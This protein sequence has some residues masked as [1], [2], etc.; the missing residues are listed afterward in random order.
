MGIT[1]AVLVRLKS[2]LLLGLVTS[3]VAC[4][5]EN[6][7]VDD[8]G[9]TDA[10]A[11]DANPDPA[12][13][14]FEGGLIRGTIEGTT[15]VFRGIPY[16]E[17]PIGDLRWRAPVP[18]APWDGVLDAT[19]FGSWCFQGGKT[20]PVGSEDC[21]FLNVWAPQSD[22]PLP[23]MVWIHGGGFQMGAGSEFESTALAEHGP[24]IVISIN[25][26]L[27]ALGFLAHPLLVPEGADH[28]A[29]NYAILD[30]IE[31]LR[32]VQG[33][34]EHLGGDKNN[35][36]IFGASAGGESVC[37]LIASPLASK[38]F[39][40]GIM[41]SGPCMIHSEDNVTAT[42]DYM[43]QRLCTNKG[44]TID[45]DCLRGASPE[46]VLLAQCPYGPKLDFQCALNFPHVDGNLLLEPTSVVIAKGNHNAVPVMIGSTSH[47]SF[48]PD[49]ESL[50]ESVYEDYWLNMRGSEAAEVMNAMYP[51][52][53]YTASETWT[54]AGQALATGFGDLIQHC[55]NR[56][57]MM[58]FTNSQADPVFHFLWSYYIGDGKLPI[59]Y[60]EMRFIFQLDILDHEVGMANFMSDTWLQFA[61]SSNPALPGDEWPTY[62]LADRA[63]TQLNQDYAS[64]PQ[65]L[66]FRGS[67]C[68]ELN[69]RFVELGKH[70]WWHVW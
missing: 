28:A 5:G 64:L 14:Q 50:P 62:E 53:D 32:W 70:D 63:Y 1:G 33:N 43:A 67:I 25:Y 42:A 52:T 12:V 56:Y 16:A 51:I 15:R 65:G 58:A 7:S 3:L 4:A 39:H 13:V 37:T 40:K 9:L 38:L 22:S 41:N 20:A 10:G 30:Q 55:T 24:A 48:F 34:I 8:A 46:D 45:V 6:P 26:R 27:G 18:K 69:T 11:V 36:T 61:K 17:P 35:V 19:Q 23:V 44:K 57:A 31:A 29:G 68:D 60:S 66:D 2:T 59:H 21:L 54:A 47:E 49:L